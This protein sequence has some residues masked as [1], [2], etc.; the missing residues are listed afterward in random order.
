MSQPTDTK[1]PGRR[2]LPTGT[3][4]LHVRIR[5]DQHEWLDHAAAFTGLG[6]AELV[7]RALDTFKAAFSVAS[8]GDKFS[9]TLATN[10]DTI[11]PNGEGEAA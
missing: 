5:H 1:R 7:R 10:P 11:E 2:P 9:P 6:K 3:E 8:K 4:T